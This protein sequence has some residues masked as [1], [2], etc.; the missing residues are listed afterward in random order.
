LEK[1]NESSDMTTNDIKDD[2]GEILP[3]SR[4]ELII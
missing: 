3:M 2:T 4:L 1:T